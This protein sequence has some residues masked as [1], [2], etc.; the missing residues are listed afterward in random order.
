MIVGA[1]KSEIYRMGIQLTV[2]VAVLSLK[3][4]GQ[5]C[6]LE[7]QAKFLCSSLE[8]ELLLLSS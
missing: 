8:A 1:G 5:A 6:R 2:G 4:I 7:T 3:Y